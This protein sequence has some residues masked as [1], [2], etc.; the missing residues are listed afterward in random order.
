[1]VIIV[2]S[3]RMRIKQVVV[4]VPRRGRYTLARRVLQVL[5]LF[6][7]TIQLVVP[8]KIVEGSLASS[9]FLGRI[10]FIDVFAFVEEVVSSRT[11]SSVEPLIALLVVIVL[12]FFLGR[13]F[14][15]WICPFDVI[16]SLFE[17][18]MWRR[19]T[20]YTIPRRIARRE[21]LVPLLVVGVYLVLSFIY[22]YPFFTTIS[23]IASTT[24]FSSILLGVLYNVPGA[25][26]GLLLG[27]ATILVGA[28]VLNTVADRVFG[29]KRLWCRYLC[30]V[31]FI[32][33]IAFNRN[34]SLKVYVDHPDKC[35]NCMLC[36]IT[37][38]MSID[39]HSFV[40]ENYVDD[41][42]CIM[43]GR[44]VEVCPTGVFKFSIRPRWRRA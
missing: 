34:S 20:R 17:R 16:L 29:V 23:P 33:G 35:I 12:Y 32:Y 28:T 37:C 2:P 41:L 21:V 15:G 3:I 27:W 38:P 44:C 25:T 13:A 11:V 10:P 31:G 26:M 18:K 7:F 14:C 5:V 43:C 4:G 40:E 39:V 30:P 22:G 1:V 36:N 8:W 9:R 42:R 24:K 19:E 6:L